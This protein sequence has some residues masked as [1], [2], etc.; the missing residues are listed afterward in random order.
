MKIMYDF[1]FYCFYCLVIKKPNDQSHI[2]ALTLQ[3]IM[4]VNLFIDIFLLVLLLSPLNLS[5]IIFKIFVLIL[6]IINI[7]VN[8][9]ENR[10]YIDNKRYEH[11][12]DRFNGRYSKFEKQLMALFALVLFS[13]SI[14]I[15]IYIGIHLGNLS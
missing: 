14:L 5:P 12:I 10:Y 4:L 13:A 2:R 7:I 8:S 6:I 9:L 15:F 3:G 1:L 11:A